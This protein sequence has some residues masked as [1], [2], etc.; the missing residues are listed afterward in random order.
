MAVFHGLW[1][2]SKVGVQESRSLVKVYGS[3]FKGH[4]S[5]LRAKGLIL[6]G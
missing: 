3:E 5:D 2:W 6:M 1:L 4:G